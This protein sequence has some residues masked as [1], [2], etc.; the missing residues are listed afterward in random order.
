MDV[1]PVDFG[2]GHRLLERAARRREEP[3]ARA[4]SVSWDVSFTCETVVRNVAKRPHRPEVLEWSVE[5]FGREKVGTHLIVGLGET[6]KQMVE[7]I[8]RADDMGVKTHLFSFFP[9]EG[10]GMEDWPQP[11]Y[12]HYR[13]IQ[14]ARYLI[15]EGL[16]EFEKMTFNGLGQLVN[17][18]TDVE[19]VI[20][21]GDAFMTSGCPGDDGQVACNRPYGN[22]RPSRPIRNFAFHPEPDDIKMVREQLFDY[23][24]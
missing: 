19:P 10:S 13:R 23:S 2:D 3:P 6:E 16:D 24:E 7:V 11:S 15:N 4:P 12:G 1:G 17:Y 8:Q 22:E 18:G 9:E 5:C 14:L 20:D 21:K